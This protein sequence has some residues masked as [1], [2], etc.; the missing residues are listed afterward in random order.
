MSPHNSLFLET[1][2]RHSPGA[3][4][5]YKDCLPSAAAPHII[6][7]TLQGSSLGPGPGNILLNLGHQQQGAAAGVAGKEIVLTPGGWRLDTMVM[8]IVKAILSTFPLFRVPTM[9]TNI[10]IHYKYGCDK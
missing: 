10:I 4:R 1:Y 9:Y 3:Q 7:I 2:F 6:V 8:V 5:K